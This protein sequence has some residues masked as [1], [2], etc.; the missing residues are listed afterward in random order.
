MRNVVAGPILAAFLAATAASA[1]PVAPPPAVQVPQA[2]Q[3]TQPDYA[4]QAGDW[5]V[6]GRF[7]SAT[8]AVCQA[9]DVHAPGLL[10]ELGGTATQA[11]AT[12]SIRT[13]LPENARA[14][15]AVL[16]DGKMATVSKGSVERGFLRLPL[17]PTDE[18]LA[19]FGKLMDSA[20]NV[21]FSA[22][23]DN[24]Y[25]EQTTISLASGGQAI[26]D[27]STCFR[28]LRAKLPAAPPQAGARPAP[29][30]TA[31]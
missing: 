13:A 30:P 1:Q 21:T 5:R 10:L 29:G 26:E 14:G 28:E 19:K 22:T 18:N 3:A 16:F 15:I 4:A 27:L 9:V 24:D 7:L 8:L 20:R 12:A 17:S 23:P 6:A 11:I 2:P 25:L 31:R